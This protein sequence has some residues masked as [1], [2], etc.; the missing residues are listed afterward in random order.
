MRVIPSSPMKKRGMD[1]IQRPAAE[2]PVFSCAVELSGIG[3]CVTETLN[4]DWLLLYCLTPTSIR[5]TTVKT[6]TPVPVP[7]AVTVP[8]FMRYVIDTRAARVPGHHI[9]LKAAWLDPGWMGLAP[10]PASSLWYFADPNRAL[11]ARMGLAVDAAEQRGDR[12]YWGVQHAGRHVFSLLGDGRTDKPG[13]YRIGGAGH[14]AASRR[15]ATSVLTYLSTH[16][17]EPVSIADLAADARVSTSTLAHTYRTATG[18]T[19]LQSL[20]RLRLDRVRQLLVTD[21]KL[22]AIA[23]ATGFYN[24]THLAREFKRR[25]GMSPAAF[26]AT[27]LGNAPRT[28]TLP[29]RVALAQL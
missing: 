29:G 24:A 9:F 11:Q 27:I 22:E 13:W 26:R 12:A 5:L 20:R 3:R 14:S 1:Y 10:D 7:G 19:P 25:E 15:L 17:A 16:L 18:E 4:H 8:P 28:R 6:F 23:E 2:G 21:M